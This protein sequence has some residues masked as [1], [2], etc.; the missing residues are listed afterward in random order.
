VS[1]F[2]EKMFSEQG[3]SKPIMGNPL[4]MGA[5]GVEVFNT[6][7]LKI[8]S[9]TFKAIWEMNASGTVEEYDEIHKIALEALKR[10]V[11]DEFYQKLTNLELALYDHDIKK[12]KE[13]IQEIKKEVGI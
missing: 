10:N 13:I 4:E 5:S 9:F 7:R 11:Y 2:I 1:D 12:G 8:I 6:P 3:K